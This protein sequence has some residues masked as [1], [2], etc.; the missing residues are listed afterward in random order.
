MHAAIIFYVTFITF[1]DS[2]ILNANHGYTTDLWTSSISA[3]TA[4]VFTVNLNLL[5]RMK[6]ITFWHGL[7]FL[8]ISYG[9]YLTF[10]WFTNFVAFGWT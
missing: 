8:L 10:M 4:L 1:Q 9:F 3:F 6:Y 5:I 7:S 2:G